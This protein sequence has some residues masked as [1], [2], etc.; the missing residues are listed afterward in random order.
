MARISLRL[1]A[2]AALLLVGTPRTAGADWDLSLFLGRAFPTFDE[3][4]T[5]RLPTVPPV[6]GLEVTPRGTPEISTDGGP[7]YGV[8][9]A[10]EAGVIGIEGRLDVVDVDLDFT[11]AGYDLRLGGQTGS[12]TIGDTVFETD[13]LNLWSL[14]LRLRTPGPVSFVVSGGLSYLPSF[15]ISG[16]VPVEVDV[17]GLGGAAAQPRLVLTAAP[18]ESENKVGVNAGAALR[19]GGR[20]G[21]FIEG[22]VFYFKSYELRAEFDEAQPLVNLLVDEIDPIDFR[23]VIGNVV[24]G[25]FFRF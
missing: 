13:R 12:V 1:A 8:A 16:T 24:V 23:P 5:I 25:L 20:V 2:V 19:F 18:E 4:L 10:G 15:D 3:R 21:L 22:R 17:P 7:V 9:L 6:P 11:G 14:N